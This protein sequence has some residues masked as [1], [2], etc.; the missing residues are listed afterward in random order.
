MPV[1]RFVAT[2]LISVLTLAPAV[3]IAQ[4][5]KAD[6][7]AGRWSGAVKADVGEMQ[8]EAS[9]KIEGETIK[10]EIKTFHGN[11]RIDKAELQKDGRWKVSFTTED[12]GAG[13]LIGIVKGDA[14]AGDWDFRPNAVGTFALTRLK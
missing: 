3:V 12:G 1:S 8:I 4:Q 14:F 9:L 10:G 13:S 2:F 6:V 5:Q 7:L 11:F